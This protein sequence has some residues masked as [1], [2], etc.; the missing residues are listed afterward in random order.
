MSIATE[1]S[2][3]FVEPN[4]ELSEYRAVSPLAIV[5]LLLGA[6]SPLA[7]IRL[8]LLIVPA[9]AIFVCLLALRRIRESRG[10]VFGRKAAW[11]GMCS[12]VFFATV[13]TSYDF[14]RERLVFRQARPIADLF[15]AAL[16]NGEPHK[17]IQLTKVPSVRQPF[18]D[19]LWDHFRKDDEARDGLEKFV[20]HPLI[21]ALLSLGHRAQVRHFRDVRVE[22]AT[23]RSEQVSILYTVTY[24]KE[25]QKTSFFVSLVLD[26]ALYGDSTT[27]QWRVSL[28]RGGI[29]VDNPL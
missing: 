17:A 15:F 3:T 29:G 13:A 10:Q 25:G 4:D 1:K 9:A 14:A 26:R 21:R 8:F 12:A 5:G 27:P 19:Q 6:A 2:T 24:D 7:S 23:G 20:A 18:D 28:F 11:I 16:T 22:R